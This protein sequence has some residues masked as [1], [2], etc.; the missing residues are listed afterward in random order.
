MIREAFEEW[1]PNRWLIVVPG[2]LGI[3]AL[4]LYGPWCLSVLAGAMHWIPA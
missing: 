1:G 4:Y 2:A 3:L